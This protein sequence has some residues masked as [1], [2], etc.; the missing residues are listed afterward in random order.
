MTLEIRH[1]RSKEG[2]HM[3]TL[4]IA[5]LAKGINK[6]E[7]LVTRMGLEFSGS[8]KNRLYLKCSE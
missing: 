4:E 5:Y 8:R 2:S 1:V 7:D 3:D 6:Y